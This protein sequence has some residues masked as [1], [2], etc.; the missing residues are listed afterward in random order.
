MK[1]FHHGCFGS[2]WSLCSTETDHSH[3]T[4]GTDDGLQILKVK[5]DHAVAVKHLGHSGDG[6][7]QQFVTD[8]E[9]TGDGQILHPFNLQQPLVWY[10]ENGVTMFSQSL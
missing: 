6:A 7:D 10:H 1:R 8:T 4:T 2:A 9:G 3:A 5:V